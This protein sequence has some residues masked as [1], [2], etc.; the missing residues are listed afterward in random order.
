MAESIKKVSVGAAL[1]RIEFTDDDGILC[2]FL[3]INLTDIRLAKRLEDIAEYFS[4][5]QFSG[6]SA[7]RLQELD[8]ALVQ[9]FSYLLGYD[10]ETTLFGVLSPTSI[11]GSGEIF[12][13]FVIQEISEVFDQQIKEKAAARAAAMKKHTEK[14][15]RV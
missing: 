5:Y 13:N 15:E 4:N 2:G 14:Y 11:T 8:K 3:K 7:E 10:C 6:D 1:T 12:A 9:K